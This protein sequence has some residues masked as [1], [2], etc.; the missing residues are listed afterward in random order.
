VK[1]ANQKEE[2]MFAK[3]AFGLAVILATASGALAGT[4]THQS[5]SVSGAYSTTSDCA[6]WFSWP[7]GL[8]RDADPNVRFEFNRGWAR[9]Y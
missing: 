8:G 2:T 3:V 5:H 6:N 9:G 4:K 7:C 1:P